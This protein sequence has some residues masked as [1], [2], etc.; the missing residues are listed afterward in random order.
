MLVTGQWQHLVLNLGSRAEG[1]CTT[2]TLSAFIDCC[3]AWEVG[4]SLERREEGKQKSGDSSHLVFRLGPLRQNT[5]TA[6]VD[7]SDIFLLADHSW[8]LEDVLQ[9]F[10]LDSRHLLQPSYCP[11]L[12]NLRRVAQVKNANIAKACSRLAVCGERDQYRLVAHIAPGSCNS[13][14][15]LPAM[16]SSLGM[17][18]FLLLPAA[19][20][21]AGMPDETI[22]LAWNACLAAAT[23]SQSNMDDFL[24]IGGFPLLERLLTME[25]YV[26]GP[27]TIEAI[28]QQTGVPALKLLLFPELIHTLLRT[29]L[30]NTALAAEFLEPVMHFINQYFTEDNPWIESNLLLAQTSLLPRDASTTQIGSLSV[31]LSGKQAFLAI[32]ACYK[33]LAGEGIPLPLQE[34][35]SF[36]SSLPPDAS[37]CRL[38]L[39]CCL[40][41][42]PPHLLYLSRTANPVQESFLEIVHAEAVV[43]VTTAIPT[44]LKDSDEE[45]K[46]QSI[47][48]DQNAHLDLS[49]L[50]QEEDVVGDWQVVPDPDTEDISQSIP[51]PP[52]PP[53]KKDMDQL[54]AMLLELLLSCHTV[55][56]DSAA[57]DLFP[58]PALLPLL[59]HP[60]PIVH[61]PAICLLGQVLQRS[62]SAREALVA[63]N[64]VAMLANLLRNHNIS[65]QSAEA[66][67]TL[68]HQHPVNLA[69]SFELDPS[70]PP[71][72]DMSMARLVPALLSST[73]EVSLCHNLLTRVHEL[74]AH[75]PTFLDALLSF[76]LGHALL[77]LLLQLGDQPGDVTDMGCGFES[78][79]LLE[80]VHNLLRLV[81]VR[82]VELPRTL[83]EEALDL[84]F[85]ASSLCSSTITPLALDNIRVA[86]CVLLEEGLDSLQKALSPRSIFRPASASLEG[87]FQGPISREPRKVGKRNKKENHQLLA[88]FNQ[89]C[90][91]GVNF[92]SDCASAVQL[93]EGNSVEALHALSL[94]LL[95]MWLDTEVQHQGSSDILIKGLQDKFSL[96]GVVLLHLLQAPT[97]PRRQRIALV[98]KVD[99]MDIVPT[100]EKMFPTPTRREAFRLALGQ[101][102]GEAGLLC[103]ADSDLVINFYGK[104]LGK[105]LFPKGPGNDDP[106]SPVH[107]SSF[108][109][110]M[111]EKERC[112]KVESAKAAERA[113]EG[114]ADA[115]K[116]T[117]EVVKLHDE[118]TRQ[119]LDLERGEQRKKQK[120]TEKWLELVQR[121]TSP[122]G[123]WHNTNAQPD[124]LVLEN[125]SGTSRIFTRL[126]YG[127]AGLNDSRFYHPEAE[128]KSQEV[129]PLF[130]RL[131]S[132]KLE[133]RLTLSDRLGG[134]DQVITVESAQQVTATS[135]Q[136]G[137]LVITSTQVCFVAEH[138]SWG[139]PI[140]KIESI[141]RMRYQLKEVALEMFL[142]SGEAHLIVLASRETR[143]STL[144]LIEKQGVAS[145]PSGST[146]S[147]LTKQWRQG[148]ISNFHYLVHL[149]RLAGRTQNDLMQYP[150]FPWI[151]ADYTSEHLDL[152]K[153]E[154]FRNLQKP[155]AVQ[156]DGSEEKYRENYATLKE[157]GVGLGPYH[158]A[159][160]YSNTG[161]VLHYLVRLPPFTGEFIKFQDGNFD[162][163][164]RSFH[165]LS[166]SWKMASETSASDVKEL[167]PEL[168]YLSELLKNNEKLRLGTRQNGSVVNDVELPPWSGGDA[169]TFVRV[170]R[171]A[172]EA[173]RVRA[174]LAHW[175]DLVFG[176]KQKGTAA[177]EACNVFHP[178]TYPGEVGGEDDVEQQARQT[179]VETYGQTPVQLFFSPHPLPVE[180]LVE[181]E[182]EGPLHT[183]IPVME[184]VRGLAWGT[185]VGSPD[186]PA[187]YIV[188]QQAQDAPVIS[189]ISMESNDIIGLHNRAAVLANDKHGVGWGASGAVLITWGHPTNILQWKD[190]RNRAEGQQV[191]GGAYRAW[192]PPSCGV[193]HPLVANFWLGHTSGLVSVFPITCRSPPRLGTPTQLHAHSATLSSI[194]LSPQ[195]G[196]AVSVD[197]DGLLVSW[198]LHSLQERRYRQIGD[199]LDSKA[200]IRAAISPTSGD[201]AV[202]WDGHLHLL[203]VNL[204]PVVQ[205]N[206]GKRI[207]SLAFSNQEEG[208]AVNCVAVG[209]HSGVVR[210]YSGFNLQ[211]VREVAG[212]PSAPVISLA[213]SWDSRNLVVA[214]N[215]GQVTILEKSGSKGTF[216]T[217]KYLTLQ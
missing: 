160:H 54:L 168:F 87:D 24:A 187:P 182:S 122:L 180:E 46:R 80:D 92:I 152:G 173:P 74:A 140:T 133:G 35:A 23:A 32:L 97:M 161:I 127:Y 183:S 113:G 151:L 128:H 44:P 172:L 126:K 204:E 207:S 47:Q 89:L 38:L 107:H 121:Q 202:G 178:A 208:I 90:K 103:S 60:R 100:V 181:S 188:W 4:L 34:L 142:S 30:T 78:D 41:L 200:G 163:P 69:T 15:L 199:K 81:M 63:H 52:L 31:C 50:G 167:I 19:A 210:L 37:T 209:L 25:D 174:E 79:L 203:N 76:G 186:Q 135:C 3:L 115:E 91:F 106:E 125:I 177:L 105:R 102:A 212:L 8:G 28:L 117:G 17:E 136:P 154:T 213:Y 131:T 94:A 40:L 66:V 9:D 56:P 217:P 82:R 175:I 2:R 48:I 99:E 10:L 39:A 169:R 114:T 118:L 198:D 65:Q 143:E 43:D 170:H 104:I 110:W 51:T 11:R 55:L 158:F 141:Q 95:N 190:Q 145:V 162:L 5:G 120:A 176:Y 215:D 147:T 146:L 85:F 137:E 108:G 71:P 13:W 149:N 49:I 171:Q 123:P 22:A 189:L 59:S 166:T 101:L 57:K 16:L 75:V 185:W 148:L 216:R 132:Q 196:L 156:K 159:S 7:A 130:K 18:A 36:L 53:E 111:A 29:M 1:V 193:S 139:V 20:V 45:Q 205:A 68:L 192:E 157:M 93:E 112:H 214:T 191:V 150:V 70:L 72:L 61:A 155:I 27:L 86:V 84:L 6:I 109:P 58:M 116:I 144:K 96:P 33:G 211:L 179:M 88:R 12:L 197:Q 195:F 42:A 98:R 134:L 129:F 83:Y 201:I 153:M 14:S 62:P 124:S 194:L 206:I 64:G 21:E 77:S 119:Q 165:S 164:D 67:F 184:S 26:P 138:T 73:T